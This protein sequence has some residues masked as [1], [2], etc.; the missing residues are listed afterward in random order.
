MFDANVTTNNIQ[1][2]QARLSFFYFYNNRPLYAEAGYGGPLNNTLNMF[3]LDQVILH[4][5]PLLHPG[6]GPLLPKSWNMACGV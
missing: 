6:A 3:S 4:I 5:K 1:C 2:H